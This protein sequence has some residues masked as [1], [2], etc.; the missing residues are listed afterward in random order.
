VAYNEEAESQS[1][2]S[3]L[4]VGRLLSR[5]VGRPVLAVLYHDDDIL[6]YWLFEGG[7]LVDSYNTNPDAFEE[8]KGAPPRQAGDREKPCALLRP[9]E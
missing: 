4:A 9:A 1:M 7:E 3:I 2:R 6:C 5:E 8:E